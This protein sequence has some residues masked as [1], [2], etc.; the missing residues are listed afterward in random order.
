MRRKL[1][2][3][4]RVDRVGNHPQ[5]GVTRGEAE[6]FRAFDI[7]LPEWDRIG[8]TLDARTLFLAH[9]SFG[10]DSRGEQ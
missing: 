4:S 6:K 1:C 5:I 10:V 7:L 9:Q 8:I 3:T 2:V